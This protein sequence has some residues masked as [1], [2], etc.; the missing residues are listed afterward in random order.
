M[1][2]YHA[3]KYELNECVLKMHFWYVEFT[4]MEDNVLQIYQAKD[5][6]QGG[7]HTSENGNYYETA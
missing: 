3:D 4:D 6:D 7:T 2:N 1:T 5:Y